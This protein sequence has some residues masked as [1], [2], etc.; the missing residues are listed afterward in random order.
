MYLTTRN[1]IAAILLTFAGS[2]NATDVIGH[3]TWDCDRAGAPSLQ[4]VKLLFNTP[5]NYRASLLR[6][7]LVNRLRAECQT[8]TS[9]L[10][11]VLNP[12]PAATEPRLVAALDLHARAGRESA[13]H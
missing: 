12:L 7:R 10:Q 5:S 3:L 11:V 8:G 9:R 13:T 6:E 1:I 4:E 2:A